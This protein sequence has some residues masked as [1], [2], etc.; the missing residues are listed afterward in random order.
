M[1]HFI[2]F[3]NI[4]MLTPRYTGTVGLAIDIDAIK[5]VSRDCMVESCWNIMH[6]G[7]PTDFGP[8]STF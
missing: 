4:P 2:L 3:R 6:I 7:Y 5:Y 1:W 8:Q